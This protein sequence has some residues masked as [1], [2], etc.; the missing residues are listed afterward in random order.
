[1][2]RLLQNVNWK[3]LASLVGLMVAVGLLWNT[4]VV[5]PLKILVVFFHEMSHGLVA[6]V[7]GGSVV[8]IQVVA[9]QG[10]LCLTI[11]GNRFLTLS[12]GYLGSLIWGGAILLLAARTR[13]DRG[14]SVVLGGI[15]VLVSLWLVR[16]FASFGFL[17]GLGS[18][19]VLVAAGIFLFEEL[20]DYLLRVVGLTSCLYAVL[21]IKSDILD[22]PEVRSDAVMLAELTGIPSMVWGVLWIALA[23]V[24][25]LL[26]LLVSCKR[27]KVPDKTT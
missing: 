21:D 13:L 4:W 14:V 3:V 5:Y 10:G 8:K 24:A 16:P 23:V 1:M 15:L 17:F 7:T 22:R 6:V 9:Q 12:A 2:A 11:G 19:L 27:K 25:S 20:N 18:G 26:F